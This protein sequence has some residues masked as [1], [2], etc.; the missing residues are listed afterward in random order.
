MG[1][2]SAATEQEGTVPPL[3]GTHAWFGDALTAAAAEFGEAEAYIDG[4]ERLT[5]AQWHLRARQVA[6]ELQRR[7]V[8]PGD[9][10]AMLLPTSADYA[11]CYAGIL[12]A[13]AVATGLN[14]RLGPMETAAILNRARPS[15]VVWDPDAGWDTPP[16]NVPILERS[17]LASIFAGPPAVLVDLPGAADDAAVIVWTS[18]TTG[19]PKGAWFDHRSLAAAAHSS[20]VMSAPFDRRLVSTPFAHAGYM[21]KVWDQLAWGITV[22]ID[23]V[24]WTAGTTV[25]L[26]RRE[27]IT[28]AAAVPTQWDKLTRTPGTDGG[29]PHLRLGT[30]ATAPASPD[31]IDRVATVF[32]IPLVVRY[33][34]TESPS[35][36][37]TDPADPPDVQF[38]TVGRPQRGMAV[39]VVDGAG[40]DVRAGAVGAVLVRGACVMRGYWNDA[41]RTAAAF[42]E[43]G[44]L[45]TADLGSLSEDAVLTLCG[46]AGDLYIRGGYNVHPLEVENVLTAHPAITQAAVVGVP[47]PVIGEVGVAF[48]VPAIEFPPTLSELRAWVGRFLADYKAPDRMVVVDALPTTAM[49]KVDRAA[50]R[51]AAAQGSDGGG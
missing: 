23:P 2:D 34:M 30:S 33:A 13:G 50:L 1:S 15:V 14:P 35:I 40:R 43:D 4:S 11:V 20:G 8:R 26:L 6:A 32:G 16:A 5:F 17:E 46:R 3:P 31:L 44:W 12:C 25:E 22:V 10:V 47:A 18:G 27:R 29:F 45:R 38:R 48:V 41:E 36:T 9:V 39:R 28:V 19:T 51:G 7:G 42:A 21:A 49:M 37:G 24:P